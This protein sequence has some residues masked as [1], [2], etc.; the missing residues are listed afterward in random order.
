M[1]GNK[2]DYHIHTTYSDGA[3][4]PTQIIKQ[5]KELQYDEI[6]ITDHDNTEGLAEAMIAA[7]AVEMKI[8][9]GIELATETEEG[10]GLHILGYRIDP[11]NERLLRKCEFLKATRADR[12]V[13][14]LAHLREMG[15]DISE[16]DLPKK[17]GDY[18][19][20]PDVVRAL[21][22]KGYELEDPF[23]LL[24]GIP[25]E[26]ISTEEAIEIIREAG[27]T[28]VLAHPF[29]IRELS[30][31]EV[32][33][34][35]RLDALLRDLKKLGIRGLECFHPSAN[36]EESLMLVELAEKYHRNRTKGSDFHGDKEPLRKR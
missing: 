26:R 21:L 6:A 16:K 5:A 23:A 24:E 3:S 2:V 10:I 32:G 17:P 29:K 30:P 36:H 4:T 20:K 35:D 18:I 14:M 7:E 12:N 33:F 13:R 25:R 15:Y 22:A 1:Q 11:S 28:P 31:R 19:G 27:G 8:I 9:P 34:R